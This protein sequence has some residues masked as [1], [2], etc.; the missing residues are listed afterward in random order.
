MLELAREE[1]GGISVVVGD[2]ETAPAVLAAA[3]WRLPHPEGWAAALTALVDL[4]RAP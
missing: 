3:C 4:L 2:D 1:D